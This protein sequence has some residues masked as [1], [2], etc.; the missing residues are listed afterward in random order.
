M[1]RVAILSPKRT[2]AEYFAPSRLTVARM[3]MGMRQNELAAQTK[4]R[5]MRLSRFE[6]GEAVPREEEVDAIASALSVDPAFFFLPSREIPAPENFTFRALTRMTAGQ[7]DRVKATVPVVEDLENFLASKLRLPDVDVPDF[8]GDEP[9]VAASR[10]REAW[11]IGDGPINCIATLME[12]HGVRVYSIADVGREVSGVSIWRNGVPFVILEMDGNAPEVVRFAAGHELAHLV[13]HRDSGS[14]SRAHEGEAERF[15]SALLMP[16]EPFLA[17]LP[18]T[19]TLQDAIQLK[20]RWKVPAAAI[21]RRAHELRAI[22]AWQYQM[23]FGELSRR[24]WRIN[25]PEPCA[26]FL[27]KR[28]DAALRILRSDGWTLDG[29]AAE[30]RQS[31]AWLNSV[32]SGLVLAAR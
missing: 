13:L 12:R 3:F 11:G 32:L 14:T 18:S 21:I 8:A 6:S 24:G 10:L 4:L 15:S 29:I 16:R 31:S 27:S 22:P 30:L 2:V 9:E 5:A 26:P 1:T 20:A 17:A 28:L 23:M 19:L 25:E 7:R